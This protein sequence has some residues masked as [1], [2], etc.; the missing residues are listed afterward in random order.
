MT[1]MP[2]IRPRARA[3]SAATALA[4]GLALALLAACTSSGSPASSPSP[5][6][7]LTAALAHWA[8]FPAGAQ[9]RP[10]VILT[11][12]Q[13]IGPVTFPSAADQDAFNAGAITLPRSLPSGPGRLGGYSLISA[14]RAAQ[15]L[16]AGGTA[17]PAPSTKLTV[18][19]VKLTSGIF[20]TDRGRQVL[21]AWQFT[22]RGVAGP[23]DVLAVATA[24]RFWPS[25][26]KPVSTRTTAAQPG[27][28][29]R[30]LTLTVYGAPAGTGACQVTYS[31]RQQSSAHA[32]AVDVIAQ[33]HDHG[34]A[35]PAGGRPAPV[36][37]PVT[38]AA[39]LG[40]RVLVDARSSAPI[41]VTQ[42]LVSSS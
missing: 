10:V 2:A 24:Q 12:D 26:L 19:K 13:V 23:A 1:G 39:P 6:T 29:G 27:R 42:P 21:P 20:A 35:C 15:V 36:S 33:E 5:G 40:N 30:A 11:G 34:A 14:A 18:T 38:L 37:L 31:V 28:S 16:T 41:P 9:V 4:F 25:G 8:S 17:S 3:R 7:R 32:V 22:L